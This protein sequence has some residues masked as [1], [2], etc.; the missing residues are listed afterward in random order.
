MLKPVGVGTELFYKLREKGCYYVDKTPL[1]RTVFRDIQSDIML[2]TRPRRF[3][4][5]LTMSTFHDFLAIN[6]EVPGDVSRQENW[7]RGT[8]IF[9]DQD[10]CREYMGKFPVIFI[11]LKAIVNSNFKNAY[12][13]FAFTIHDV[14]MN[15]EYLSASTVLSDRQKE[16]Y[17]NL[18]R[19]EKLS[20]PSSSALLTGSL[21]TLTTLLHTHHGRRPIL[22]IDEYDVPLAKAAHHGY[23]N[24]MIEILSPFYNQTLKTNPDL[25]RAVLTGC[26]RAA[27]ESI[28]TGLNNLKICSLLD[29]ERNNISQGIGF[30]QEETQEV[31]SYYN[32]TDY[33]DEV[34]NNYDGYFF[35]NSHMYCPWDVMSFCDDYSE[36]SDSPHTRI[37][38]KNYWINTSGND[39]IEEFM[40][41]ISP[42]DTDRMQDLLDGKPVT[43]KIRDSLCYGDLPKHDITD[44]W[45]LLLYTGYLTFDPENVREQEDDSEELY[46]LR[47]PNLEIRKCFRDKIMDFLHNSPVMKNHT[48]ELIKALF[49][50]DQEGVQSN[51]SGLLAKYVSLRDL[52]TKAPRENYYHG[53]MNGLLVNGVSLVGEHRSS[54]ESGDG[55][56]DLILLSPQEDV[57]TV[58]ELKTARS[59]LDDKIAKA[60][61][62]IEQIIN[63]DYAGQFMDNS[64]IQAVY[65]CG[66]CFHRKTCAVRIRQLK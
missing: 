63:T 50:G 10:F 61:K 37:K 46:D 21:K 48:T 59:R 23:Y 19:Y 20:D 51:L 35:G 45:T 26:L 55:Y 8:K 60:E 28:F 1:I 62:A 65:A 66:I 5:T 34:R 4:K 3:G 58:L 32:L 27:K 9:Q 43:T 13:Q 31:L 7:F 40:D 2:I 53:F 25:D 57:V 49:C 6:P 24:D 14:A 39:I 12:K 11:S 54:P 33:F 30:T 36:K 29:T 56:A 44:F 42:E 22:L 47:I 18:T 64:T 52:T 17:D 38:A 15:F 16:Q 41:F